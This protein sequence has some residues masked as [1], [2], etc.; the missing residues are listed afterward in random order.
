M[1]SRVHVR[2]ERPTVHSVKED[3]DTSLPLVVLPRAGRRP[4]RFRGLRACLHEFQGTNGDKGEIVLWRRQDRR[5]AISIS[6]GACRAEAVVVNDM[7]A[8]CSWV[9]TLCGENDA[10]PS[11]ETMDDPIEVL[12]WLETRRDDRMWRDLL[13]MRAGIILQDWLNCEGRES[14]G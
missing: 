1:S 4:L 10:A 3:Q 5:L 12:A 11:P 6:L 9:E 7:Q 14:G 13:A 8:A 2:S